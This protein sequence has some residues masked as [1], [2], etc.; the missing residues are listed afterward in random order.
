MGTSADTDVVKVTLHMTPLQWNMLSAWNIEKM[1]QGVDTWLHMSSE[2][3]D[4]YN[5]TIQEVKAAIAR[6]VAHHTSSSGVF[7]SS[8][9][10]LATE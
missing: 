4:E 2:Q 7:D 5:A 8:S 10:V 9:C 1:E 6:T 3:G